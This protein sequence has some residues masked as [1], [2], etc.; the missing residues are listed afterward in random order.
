MIDKWCN[1]VSA[2]V[3]GFRIESRAEI[4]QANIATVPD[5]FVNDDWIALSELLKRPY[6]T[7]IWTPQAFILGG[8]ATLVCGSASVDFKYLILST[9]RGSA[10]RVDCIWVA[11]T[12]TYRK[13]T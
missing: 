1:A 3:E 4:L 2:N 12:Q 11:L 9:F 13:Q 6:W 10:L 8:R 7:R 5:A